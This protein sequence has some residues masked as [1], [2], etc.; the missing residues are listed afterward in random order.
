MC[1][2]VSSVPWRSTCAF[3]QQMWPVVLWSE[4]M[5]FSWQSVSLMSVSVSD[6]ACLSSPPLTSFAPPPGA[7]WLVL[8]EPSYPNPRGG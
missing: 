2:S 1:S 6:G 8:G 3:A 4:A 7:C 5:I